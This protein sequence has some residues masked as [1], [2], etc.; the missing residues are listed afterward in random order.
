MMICLVCA[1][2]NTMPHMLRAVRIKGPNGVGSVHRKAP[3][4]LVAEFARR[5]HLLLLCDNQIA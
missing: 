3:C 4:P 1:H 5:M 2:A